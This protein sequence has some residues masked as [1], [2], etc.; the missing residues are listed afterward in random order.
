MRIKLPQKANAVFRYIKLKFLPKTLF[1][2]TMLLI[3]VPLIVVQAVSIVAFFDGSWGKVGRRLSNNLTS[4]MAFVV[5]M[6]QAV[7]QSRNEISEL[8]EKLYDIKVNYYEGEDRYLTLKTQSNKN[9]MV[10]GF[11]EKSLRNE[12]PQAISSVYMDKEREVLNVYLDM[13]KISVRELTILNSNL[14]A[15]LK[16]AEPVMLLSK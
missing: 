5:E 10:T 12:F 8:S 6:M 3:F 1:F 2:R 15:Q 11:L 7:P 14:T 9:K 13:Q 4:N 16:Y